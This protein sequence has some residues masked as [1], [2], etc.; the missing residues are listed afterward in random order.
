MG[1]EMGR[2]GSKWGRLGRR[3]GLLWLT[4]A[5]LCPAAG[6]SEPDPFAEFEA[7]SDINEGE[8]A[9]LSAPPKKPYPRQVLH[10]TITP[11]S[12]DSGWIDSRQCFHD[13]DPAVAMQ[14]VFRPG[15]VRGLAIESVR[16][17]GRAW[18][19]GASVQL[20][21]VRRRSRLCLRSQN[22]ALYLDRDG[23][24]YLG[25]GPHMRRFLD[26]YFPMRLQLTVRFPADRLRL[27]YVKPPAVRA[28]AGPRVQVGPA[29]VYYEALFEGE[30][31]VLMRFRRR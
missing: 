24:V 25:T 26:G 23:S 5:L 30:L 7:I 19:E 13:L 27:V 15:R 22:R 12:L 10:N 21:D 28:G 3:A 9:F 6:Q 17:I 8:L 11:E 2:P 14:V 31:R 1:S 20:E 16:N 18:V 29:K 4:A